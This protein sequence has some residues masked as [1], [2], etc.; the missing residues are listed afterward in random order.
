MPSPTFLLQSSFWRNTIEVKLA[1]EANDIQAQRA[2]KSIV[3]K[4]V[5]MPRI[6]KS[7][8]VPINYKKHWMLAVVLLKDHKILL[9]NSLESY[10]EHIDD[11]LSP[12]VK[13]LER[14]DQ[15]LNLSPVAWSTSSPRCP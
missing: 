5:D 10:N 13:V 3:T 14:R 11:I 1:E 12:I 6:I 7:M 4:L 2:L 8:L 15:A 9:L